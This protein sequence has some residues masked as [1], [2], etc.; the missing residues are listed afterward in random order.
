L[1]GRLEVS[2][3]FGGTDQ[4]GEAW[5]L[6]GSGETGLFSA[7]EAGA[8]EVAVR[9][10]DGRAVNG[11]FWLL[12][13]V[14]SKA[15]VEIE[16]VDLASGNRRRFVKAAGF[17]ANAADVEALSASAA[18]VNVTLDPARAVTKSIGPAGGSVEATD[19]GGT[20][21]LLAVPKNALILAVEVT[22]TPAATIGGLPFTGGLARA[23]YIQPQG[24]ILSE[25]GV[26]T[27]TPS[28]ALPRAQ[29]LTFAFRGLAGELSL[30]PPLARQ[31]GQTGLVLPVHRFGGYGVGAGTAA[32]LAAQ[33]GRLPTRLE[34]RFLQRLAGLLLPLHRAGTTAALPATVGQLLQQEYTASIKPAI[35]ALKQGNL[36][37]TFPIVR[38]WENAAKDTGQTAK[39]T[40]QLQE[41]QSA[42]IAGAVTSYNA[43]A[44]T[45]ALQSAE[46][47][48]RPCKNVEAAGRMIR[49][50]NLL[51]SRGKKGLVAKDKLEDCARFELKWNTILDWRPP[52][53][54]QEH[55]QVEVA[56][57]LRYIDSSGT[58]VWA[59]YSRVTEER[60]TATA[61]PCFLGLSIV[62]TGAA[63]VSKLWFDLKIPRFSWRDGDDFPEL[64]N[65][66][67]YAIDPPANQDWLVTCGTVSNPHSTSW[68]GVY[69]S[70]HLSEISEEGFRTQLGPSASPSVFLEKVYSQGG[71]L[72]FFEEHTLISVFFKPR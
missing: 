32:D 46:A 69:T 61:T 34:D 18:V 58:F 19:S 7:S 41:I 11:H 13:S 40:T 52:V 47:A 23:V 12:Y 8:A 39:L 36:E 2:A 10:V 49:A 27:I 17:L 21:F 24:L 53:P 44:G 67:F 35:T 20:R 55:A 6:A 37:A 68:S 16:L 72:L 9:V 62:K 42:E 54:F 29:Q 65:P 51:K 3:R 30:A 14:L 70:F 71:H 15:E 26:M 63:T 48:R 33:L 22:L 66:L 43:A 31:T 5:A 25:S 38:N 57:A 28:P 60:I 50:Y 45:T 64:G 1:G 4:P 56:I 59:K